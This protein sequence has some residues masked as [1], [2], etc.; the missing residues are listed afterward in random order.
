MRSAAPDADETLS[1]RMPYYSQHGR[2]IYFAVFRR[3]VGVYLMGRSK[4]RFAKH[5]TP[6]RTSASTLRFGFGSKLPVTLLGRIVRARL[7]ENLAAAA[8][9]RR[10][11]S[12]RARTAAS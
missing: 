4:E 2:L 3:H 10:P 12:A 7:K 6:W 9:K 5:I 8:A 1:Y 11:K